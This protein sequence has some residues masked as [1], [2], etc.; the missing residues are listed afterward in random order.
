[1]EKIKFVK[2]MGLIQDGYNGW[3]DA[4]R[5]LGISPT[6]DIML[7]LIDGMADVVADVV[8]DIGLPVELDR[9]GIMRTCGNDLPLIHWFCWECEFGRNAKTVHVGSDYEVEVK[10]AE[11]L[12]ALIEKVK[13]LRKVK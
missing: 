8:G 2:A 5:A 3:N 12:Y 1:M 11:D 9:D 10:T 6:F 7:R 4:M 13:E